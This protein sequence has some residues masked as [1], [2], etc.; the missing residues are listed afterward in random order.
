MHKYKK[1]EQ[2]G[3]AFYHQFHSPVISSRNYIKTMLEKF[4]FKTNKKSEK[5]RIFTHFIDHN[6]YAEISKEKFIMNCKIK[7]TI[8]IAIIAPSLH[9]YPHNFTINTLAR[10]IAQS[11]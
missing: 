11:V 4:Q 2:Q 7:K 10:L 5:Y 6:F 3:D 9:I 8:P 1:S